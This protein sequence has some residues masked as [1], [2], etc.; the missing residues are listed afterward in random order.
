M[1]VS[2]NSAPVTD[3][4]TLAISVAAIPAGRAVPMQVLRDGQEMTVSIT[5]GTEQAQQ[6][7]ASKAGPRRSMGANV[8]LELSPLTQEHRQELGLDMPGG[9]LVENVRPGS[10]ADQSGLQVGDVILGIGG[11]AVSSPDDASSRIR[12]AENSNRSAL[13]LLVLRDGTTAYVA[14]DLKG[15]SGT[16]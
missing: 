12:A 9:V 3:T 4:R 7:I 1:I 8:G 10:P 15:D 2:F 13:P 5:I 11:R 6:K 14:L 16:G